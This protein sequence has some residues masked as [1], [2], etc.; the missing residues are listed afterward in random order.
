MNDY[1]VI[2]TVQVTEKGTRLR[3]RHNQY[4][5]K[6]ALS[7][8]K[9]EVKRAVENLFKVH[10]E[11]VNIMNYRGKKRRERSARYGRRPDWK[12]AVVTV[13]AGDA[14]ELV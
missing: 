12:R 8:N 11:R 5:F 2:Q 4:L 7:A 10:V 3:E 9:M 13:K 14:I 6:V 1:A